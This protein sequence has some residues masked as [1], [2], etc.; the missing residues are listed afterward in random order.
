MKRLCLPRIALIL[1][2]L[3]LVPGFA[4]ASP[5][6]SPVPG[7]R[8]GTLPIGIYTCEMPGDAAGPA[9]KPV[10]DHEFRVV[11]ASSYKAGGTRGSYLFTGSRVTMTGG[12]LKGLIL[13]RMSEGFLRKVNKD[14][15]DGEMRCVL[16]SRR[17][18]A[19]NPE[20]Q[21]GTEES[22]AL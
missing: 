15:S 18:T 19:S 14:G 4:L 10:A 7:G 9:G 21:P 20:A 3:A 13:H 6:P 8:I 12:K 17:P 16:T 1:P 11:N 5:E 22:D 2:L